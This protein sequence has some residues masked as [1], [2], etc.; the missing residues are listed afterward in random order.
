MAFTEA[1]KSIFFGWWEPDFN[2]DSKLQLQ[3]TVLIFQTNF[4]KTYTS[5]E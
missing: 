5:G 1:N 3:Q 2:L 4:Q